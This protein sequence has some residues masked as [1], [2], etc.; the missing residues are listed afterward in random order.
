M[1]GDGVEE[2]E[3]VV[4]RNGGQDGVFKV[5]VGLPPLAPSPLSTTPYPSSLSLCG[6]VLHHQSPAA[7]RI[8]RVGDIDKMPPDGC[9]PR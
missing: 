1:W 3:T 9:R 6:E 7:I 5:V 4:V 8:L 2:E